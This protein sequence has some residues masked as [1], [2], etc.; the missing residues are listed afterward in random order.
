M[1]GVYGEINSRGDYHRVLSE[2]L[3]I[4]QRILA[5]QPNYAVLQRIH[6]ELDAIKKWTEN[7]REPSKSERKSV[8]VGLIAAREFENAKGE[9]AALVVKLDGLNNY[10]EAWPTDEKAATATEEDFF[11]GDEEEEDE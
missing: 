1:A 7:G 2:A 11:D 3:D 9:L 5:K 4:T 8:D 6:T 10:F